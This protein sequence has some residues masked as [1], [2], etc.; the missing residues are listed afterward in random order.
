[1]PT[2]TTRGVVLRYTNYRDHDRMLSVLTP[3]YGRVDALSRGCRRPKSPLMPCSELFVHGEFVFYHSH[4]RFTLTGC[5]LHDTF[6]PLRMEPYR[7]TCASYMAALCHAAVQPAQEASGLYGLL[8]KGLYYLAYDQQAD[9]LELTAAYLLLFAD[10]TGYRPRLTR[11]AHCRA[12]IQWDKGGRF[13]SEAGGLCCDSCASRYTAFLTA[14][15]I[16]WLDD[17]LRAGLTVK[18][19][20]EGAAL[21]ELLRRYVENRL[22]TPIKVSRLLP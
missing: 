8:L 11:C 6:Y 5:A 19:K 4:D 14:P 2:I 12:P 7:L 22:E 3:D 10:M 16:H 13:D 20:S 21:F 17:T 9:P 1:M 18:E 15:Q